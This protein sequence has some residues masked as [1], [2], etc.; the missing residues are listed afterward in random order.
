VQRQGCTK[1]LCGVEAATPVARAQRLDRLDLDRLDLAGLDWLI[2][3]GESGPRHRPME[4]DWA[5]DLRERC[6]AA[7]VAFFFKQLS[8]RR[9]DQGDLDAER[10]RQ[11][12]TRVSLPPVE[13]QEVLPE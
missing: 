4:A 9:P 1:Q 3:G 10:I 11:F 13:Q 5:G 7:G 12:P 6:P 8:H 2:V